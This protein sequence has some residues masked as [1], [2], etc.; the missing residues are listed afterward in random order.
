MEVIEVQTNQHKQVV[1]LTDRIQALVEKHGWPAGICQLSL[2]HTSACLTTADLDPGTDL[3]L[4]DALQA[5]M[6]QLPYRHPHDPSHVG[7]HIWHSII[8]GQLSLIVS[9]NHL[10]LGQWQRIVLIELNGPRTRRLAVEF[11][12]A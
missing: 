7:D 12:A 6:P 4:L 8:G 10:L 11:L 2:L 5:I 3:D 9:H 1:D